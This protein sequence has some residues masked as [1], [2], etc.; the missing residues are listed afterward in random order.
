[1][2]I[3]KPDGDSY[4][5]SDGSLTTLASIHSGVE[6]GLPN[7]VIYKRNGDIVDGLTGVRVRGNECKTEKS[8]QETKSY[9]RDPKGPTDRKYRGKV[10]ITSLPYYTNIGS[11]TEHWRLKTNGKWTHEDADKIS[12]VCSGN[13]YV[14]ECIRMGFIEFGETKSNKSQARKSEN[15]WGD[16][17]LLRIKNGEFISFHYV[18]ENGKYDS[19]PLAITW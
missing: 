9:K 10:W 18:I 15:F 16:S 4:E 17:R 5:I 6:S 3:T 11:E 1:M 13:V 7:V 2:Y 8:A 14:K 19:M 12:T